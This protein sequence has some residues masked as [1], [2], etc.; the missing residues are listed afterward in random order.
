[1]SRSRP[2][3]APEPT[4]IASQFFGQQRLHA[5]D[6]L[7]AAEFDAEVE[8]V[9]AFLVDDGIGQAEF[10]NLRAD[11][12]AGFWILVEH[13]AVVAERGEIAGDGERG[14]AAA[15][16]RDAFAVLLCRGLW[17]AIAN[18]VL[19]VGRHSFQA[20]DRHRLLLDADAPAGRLARTVAG[21]A[22]EFPE[23]HSSA[24]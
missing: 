11:H 9:A 20:A 2:R 3:G 1:M 22:R 17:Q 14:R 15:D 13:D 18:V 19:V 6:A 12:A 10:R 23:T 16:Q 24:N 5:V 4:K 7:A 8:D 21:A